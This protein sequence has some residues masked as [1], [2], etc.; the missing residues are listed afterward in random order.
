[1]LTCIYMVT[2]LVFARTRLRCGCCE[3]MCL[4]NSDPQTLVSVT[5]LQLFVRPIA[6]IYC[7]YSPL[8]GYGRYSLAP[9]VF[10]YL[11][12]IILL[13]PVPH[14]TRRQCESGLFGW[15]RWL[16]RITE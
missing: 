14:T 8:R 9:T 4:A 2:A 7:S 11:P 15:L 5:P 1:M 12:T 10:P 6:Y 3:D 16:R 13:L